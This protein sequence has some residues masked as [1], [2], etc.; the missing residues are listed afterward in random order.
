MSCHVVGGIPFDAAD[1]GCCWYRRAFTWEMVACV[2]RRWICGVGVGDDV[3]VMEEDP[4][5]LFCHVV[6]LVVPD[7]IGSWVVD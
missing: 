2:G 5:D 4:E 3:G 1:V 7:T 6:D